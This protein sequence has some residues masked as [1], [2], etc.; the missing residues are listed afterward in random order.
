MVI[1]WWRHPGPTD[2]QRNMIELFPENLPGTAAIYH[3]NFKISMR[4]IRMQMYV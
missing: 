1:K 3:I 2:V 4:N